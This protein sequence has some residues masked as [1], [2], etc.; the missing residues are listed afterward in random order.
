MANKKVSQLVSKPSVLV[1][2]LFPIADPTTGQLFKTTISALGTAIGSGVSSVNTLVG[3]V[4]LDTDDIQELATPTN[5][6][7][8]DTRSRAAISGGTGIS[9]NSGTGV[10]TNAVTSGQIATALGYTPADDALVV[11]LAGSQTIT[12]T[13]TFQQAPLV[14]IGVGFKDGNGLYNVIKSLTTGWE[15]PV[16]AW[17]HKLLFSTTANYDYT[18]PSVSG[19]V[20][21]VSDLG[22]YVPYT[23]A[24]GNVN[25]GSNFLL[26]AQ[27]KAS[28]SA[29]L[30]LNSNNGTQVANLG[31]GGG[32]NITFYGGLTG[33]IATFASSTSVTA[34]GITL[35]GSTGDGVKI[36][37][38]AGRAFNIQSSG[39][40]F[41]ILI[42][43]ET[44][45]TSSPFTI[46]KQGATVISMTDTGAIAGTSIELTN[47]SAANALRITHTNTS[48]HAVSITATG[49]SALYATG[50]VTII[51]TLNATGVVT[52]SSG[53]SNGAGQS[54]ALPSS[55]GTLALT[56]QLSSYLPL[57]GGTLT[58]ELNAS[59]IKIDGD[60]LPYIMST[61]AGADLNIQFPVGQKLSINDNGATNV[62]YFGKTEHRLL[63]NGS[64]ALTVNSGG[65]S[66]NSA[67]VGTTANFSGALVGTSA[68]FSGNLTIDTNTFFVNSST[69]RVGIRNASPGDTFVVD[70]NTNE[71]GGVFIAPNTTSQ[72]FGVQIL[73]GTNADDTSFR[74]LNGAQ[75]TEYFKILG[76]GAATFSSSV[77]VGNFLTVSSAST[78]LAPSS[79]KSIEMVY[80]TDGANDYAFIQAYDRTNSVFKRLDF[81]SAVTI[82]ANGNVGIGTTAPADS[83]SFGKAL[84]VSGTN[85]AALYLR[86]STDPSSQFGM[87]GYDR[88]GQGLLMATNN[89]LPIIFSTSITERMRITSGGYTWAT[90][91]T[92]SG[93]SANHQF[94]NSANGNTII[95]FY[96][97]GTDPY[98]LFTQFTGAAPNNTTNYFAY[99]RDTSGAKCV[100]FSN[101][102]IQNSN[103][104]YGAI[105]DIKLKE[106]ITDASS[107]LTD[108]LKVKIR[109][110]NLIGDTNKQIGVIAQEL[111]EVFP[112]LIEETEDRD[113]NGYLIGT[114]TKSVKYSVF[115]PMLI[116]AV[117]E[118]SDKITTLENK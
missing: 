6:W 39:S 94:N 96:H 81:N 115:V 38:S 52:A 92:Y 57:S 110:Y 45:S 102:N 68:T 9:Y 19:T 89:A 47:G 46:Q 36:T 65:T 104:S 2:D 78:L 20:A 4:V 7:Y 79:G 106:N 11:K 58:G 99:F 8:T 50:S 43:N 97:Q 83:Y 54:F 27:V 64:I 87:I 74:V 73:A 12:G 112:S 90:N 23:G 51:G 80:R 59:G 24:T 21:L 85:G 18:F 48:Y 32:A 98:G 49:G 3:A 13:K 103:N 35:S 70:A 105:S 17:N 63:I 29:G 28:S 118:L 33:T 72:S 71:W 101:G 91:S 62:A 66:L 25:I 55:T 88:T 69:N 5:K 16:N 100:I 84:D 60:P 56:S 76:N 44:A 77:N 82:L 75:T 116:K 41:G 31:A 117:Q 113:N 107:K 111:E 10:I 109:N 30:S 93:S 14:D 15:I 40:G 67:L 34:L 22:S 1:T 108:L 86:Y 53:L 26:T 114:K 95:N 42:N 61:L 37:H